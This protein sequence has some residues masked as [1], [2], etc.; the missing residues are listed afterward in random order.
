MTMFDKMANMLPTDRRQMLA[1]LSASAFFLAASKSVAAAAAPPPEK[2]LPAPDY[3]PTDSFFGKPWFDIDEWRSSPVRFRYV[4]GGFEGTDTRFAFYFP[5]KSVY[6]G[7]FFHTLPGGNGG[8]ETGVLDAIKIYDAFGVVPPVSLLAAFDNGAYLID[9][10]QGHFGND[11]SG[12]KGEPDILRFR[13]SAEVARFAREVAKAMYGT[14]P[15]HGYIY[16]GSGGAVRSINCLESIPDLWDGGVPI[17]SPMQ[18]AGIFFSV[19]ANAV[20]LL[21]PEKMA[22][23]DDAIEVGG[24]GRPF[25]G[26]DSQQAEALQILYR[27]GYP[28]SI[29]I[30]NPRE[31][32]LVW[33]YDH[34][35]MIHD[36]PSY[37]DDFWNKPGYLG[38]DAPEILRPDIMQV[39]VRVKRVLTGSELKTYTP[40][41]QVI[42]ER[43][44]GGVQTAQS[45]ARELDRPAAVVIEGGREQLARMGCASMVFQTGKAKGRERF[46]MAVLGD[47]LIAGGVGAELLE[48]VAPGDEILIDNRKYLAF[49]YY[50]RHQVEPEFKEWS[51]AVVDGQAIYPQ[52]PRLP[53][54][55]SRFPYTFAVGDRKMIFVSSLQDRGVFASGI[56]ASMNQI[57]RLRGKAFRENNTRVWLND[58]AWHGGPPPPLPG[59][60]LPSMA[61]KLINYQGA[62][63]FALRSLVRWIEK[64][65][66]PLP[67]SNYSYTED[68]AIIVPAMAS[69]RLGIQ[70][71]VALTANGAKERVEVKAGQ[72]VEFV[73]TGEMPPRAGKIVKAE[74]DFEGRGT[75][76][77]IDKSPAGGLAK[78]TVKARFIFDKPGTFFTTVR[79]TG[80]FEGKDE[81]VYAL[82]NLGRIR[83]VVT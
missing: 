52:R 41:F 43:G 59:E 83:V 72:A 62:V 22:S 8:S 55:T 56:A 37:F 30:S 64:G 68:C 51:H 5:E 20:R 9:S 71:V 79:M 14:A 77:V 48:G 3:T 11:L 39:K 12:L 24:S 32:V 78:A 75:F 40:P 23:L 6:Q 42:D 76:A 17:V 2:R 45:I 54:P 18:G 73:A 74:W 21:G 15:S 58:H 34:D 67:N 63:S 69:D 65:E 29:G 7:R 10:N 4:H 26:L 16:G 82:P 47:A 33:T 36:D 13:A 81:P 44:Q 31:A 28:R 61:S 1:S 70:P 66:L 49:C 50:H 46:V 19:L 57:E 38:H 80:H 25:D 53:T 60:A 27:S 35:A